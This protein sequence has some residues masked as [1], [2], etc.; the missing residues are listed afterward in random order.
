MYAIFVVKVSNSTFH[1]VSKLS[2]AWIVNLVVPLSCPSLHAFH[3]LVVWHFVVLFGEI[4]H[5][6]VH[7]LLKHPPPSWANAMSDEN[8]PK[9]SR[10]VAEYSGRMLPTK[11]QHEL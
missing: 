4:F 2:Y 5:A 1:W 9:S 11:G 7:M 6:I 3:D 10:V 8:P